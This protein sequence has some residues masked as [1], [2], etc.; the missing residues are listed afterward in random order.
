MFRV[1]QVASAKSAKKEKNV[2]EKVKVAEAVIQDSSVADSQSKL[3]SA[4]ASKNEKSKDAVHA[5]GMVPSEPDKS[6]LRQYCLCR[7]QVTDMKLC[8]VDHVL[9]L[10][11]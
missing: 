3:S 11:V 1:H 10:I 4:D 9:S 2:K 5:N 6:K 7:Q 8:V